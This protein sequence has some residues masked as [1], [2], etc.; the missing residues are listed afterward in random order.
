MCV[1]IETYIREMILG[2]H[3]VGWIARGIVVKDNVLLLLAAVDNL[4]RAGVE[5]VANLADQGHDEGSHDG[6][7]ETRKLLLQLLD[8]LGKNGYLGDGRSDGLHDIVVELDGGHYLAEDS[9]HVERKLLRVARRDRHV[10][11]LSRRSIGLNLVNF[12]A[13]ISSAQ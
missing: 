2:Q 5:L 11:Y 6:E 10:L 7:D 1:L 12:R 3:G 4:G 13:L 9:G 8:N